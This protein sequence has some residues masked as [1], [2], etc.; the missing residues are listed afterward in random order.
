MRHYPY[1]WFIYKKEF[2][3]STHVHYHLIGT[4]YPAQSIRYGR[5]RTESLIKKLWDAAN[6][7]TWEKSID[8]QIFEKGPHNRYLTTKK[9]LNEDM[10]CVELLRGSHMIGLIGEK[11]VTFHEKDITWLTDYEK[12][13]VLSML[14]DYW[15][16]ES[17]DPAWIARMRSSIKGGNFAEVSPDMQKEFKKA[18]K[19]ATG[20]K[21]GKKRKA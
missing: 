8:V 13:M 4:L 12:S 18:V 9:K 10:H 2:K 19:I 11:N 16:Q 6:G 20:K 7:F 3:S 14:E 5:A 17:R 1:S 21:W 15:Q